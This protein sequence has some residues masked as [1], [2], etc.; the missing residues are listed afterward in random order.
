T[1]PPRSS[2]APFADQPSGGEEDPI[3]LTGLSSIVSTLV[4]KVHSLKAKL[5]DHKWLFKDVVGT[6]C[7][8]TVVPPGASDVPPGAFDVPP[9]ASDVSPGAFDAPTGALTVLPGP[10]VV[11][12]ATSDVPTGDLTVPAGNLNVPAAVTSSGA[13]AGVSSKGKSL[14]VEEDIPVKA[15]TFKQMEEDRLDEEAAKQLHDEEWLK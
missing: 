6:P 2:H 8:L 7:A 10:F 12:A 5:H 11:P 3:T 1:S 15:R 4:Q 13:S 9:G 14:M